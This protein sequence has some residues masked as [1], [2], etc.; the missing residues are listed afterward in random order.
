LRRCRYPLVVALAVAAQMLAA[1]SGGTISDDGSGGAGQPPPPASSSTTPR[2][3]NANLVNAFD[4][5]A[6]SDGRPGYFFTTPS[7][8]W[9][10]AIIPHEEAGCR[11]A[12]ST[13]SLGI[14]GI[15]ATVPDATGTEASPNAI[16][17]RSTGDAYFT[18][19]D[20]GALVRDDGADQTLQFG[21]ILAAAGFRCNVQDL[22]ISCL[23]ET[24]GS[25]F[26][27]SAEGYI[28]SYTDLPAMP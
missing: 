25:G 12:K 8:T 17:V 22:G 21:R 16:M 27:F 23:S 24:S 18:T 4:F 13:V 9:R 3:S 19:V 14:D 20:A 11:S 1:C 15:P 10:C 5:Y 7:G 2:P 28:P 6:Q 26:T